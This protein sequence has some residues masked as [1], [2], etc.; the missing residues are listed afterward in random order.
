VSEWAAPFLDMTVFVDRASNTLEHKP[1]RKPLNHFER[2]PWISAHPKDVKRG[3]FLGEMSRLATLC[4]RPGFYLE[5]IRDLKS[6]YIARGYPKALVDLWAKDNLAKRWKL[7]LADR[8]RSAENV[9]VLKSQFN[10]VWESFNIHKLFDV[11]RETWYLRCEEQPWCDLQGLCAIHNMYT[12]P[13]PPEMVR[14]V[15]MRE[16]SLYKYR[17]EGS[18]T[19]AKRPRS[20]SPTYWRQTHLSEYVVEGR[21]SAKRPKISHESASRSGS[22]DEGG[23]GPGVAPGKELPAPNAAQ[24]VQAELAPHAPDLLV[25][26]RYGTDL[27]R[28]PDTSDGT[29]SWLC[30]WEE[31][32]GRTSFVRREMLDLRKTDFFSRR[33]LV[34]RKRTRNLFDLTSTWRKNAKQLPSEQL[35]IDR[36]DVDE[37]S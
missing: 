3:T 13:K 18:S 29:R 22:S 26:C 4:S 27:P 21:L 24:G 1:Y 14:A 9:F 16:R 12:I 23:E 8:V 20:P 15:N 11:I 7:R 32:A 34:S 10:P 33:A 31:H 17:I 6:L 28:L 30:F 37:W 2:I 5:S 25:S 36:Q 35:D 19:V